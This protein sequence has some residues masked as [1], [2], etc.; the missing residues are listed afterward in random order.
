M[1]ATS[2]LLYMFIHVYDVTYVEI[3]FEGYLRYKTTICHK[4]VL[5]V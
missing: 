2:S 1:S 5:D 4:A 3:Q